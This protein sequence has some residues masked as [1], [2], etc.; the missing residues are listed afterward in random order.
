MPVSHTARAQ[1]PLE[2][3]IITFAERL[4]KDPDTKTLVAMR[5]MREF[6]SMKSRAD[7][8]VAETSYAYDNKEEVK[9]WASWMNTDLK[10]MGLNDTQVL[11]AVDALTDA[12]IKH[13]YLGTGREEYNSRQ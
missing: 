3:A 12:A 10:K 11:Q 4:D 7:S 5:M 1:F 2:A 8:N 13:G 6:A 9:D